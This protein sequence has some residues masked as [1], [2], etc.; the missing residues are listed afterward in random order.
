MLR[1]TCCIAAMLAMAWSGASHAEQGV[2]LASGFTDFTSWTKFGS[3]TAVNTTPGNGFT[4][5]LL[6]LTSTGIGGQAGAAFAPQ[7]I[8]LDLNQSFSFNFNF[9][10]RANSDIDPDKNVRGD[11]LTFT[12]AATPGVGNAGSGL[13]YEDLSN[14]V[15]FA[16]DTFHFDGE[17]V[18]PSLQI[19]Q[20]GSVTPLAVTETGLGNGIR[21]TGFQLL[22]R[23]QYTPSGG[24]DDKGTLKGSVLYGAQ[25]FSVSTEVDLSG[26][27]NTVYYGFTASNGLATDGQFITAAAPVPEPS[28]YAMLLVG[29]A[30]LAAVARKRMAPAS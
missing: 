20:N 11:G 6:S 30:L 5:S 9:F 16:V 23:V 10:I 3:A 26:L 17:P 21:D 28:T 22:G 29:M 12:L 18:S 4:Y 1:K 13:G 15:A 19:L 25:T 24:G 27:G 7:A 2:S 8:S 14:S